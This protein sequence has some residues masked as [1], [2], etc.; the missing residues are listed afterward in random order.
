M[1]PEPVPPRSSFRK[2]PSEWKAEVDSQPFEK[3][4]PLA[5]VVKAVSKAPF[6]EESIISSEGGNGW[7]SPETSR[8]EEELGKGEGPACTG[9]FAHEA[10]QRPGSGWSEWH[11]DGKAS[12]LIQLDVCVYVSRNN[13]SMNFKVIESTCGQIPI[14]QEAALDLL[15]SI[16]VLDKIQ[17]SHTQRL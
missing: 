5:D 15:R 13:D 1:E 12:P 11:T 2:R 9:G 14:F 10:E 8:L 7:S 4:L 17:I 3:P 6:P 16:Q